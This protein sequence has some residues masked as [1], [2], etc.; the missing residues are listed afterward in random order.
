MLGLSR[1][2]L[3]NYELGRST[4]PAQ[5]IDRIEK[6]FAASVDAP[7]ELEDYEVEFNELF[8]NG[9]ELTDDEWSLIRIV[10]LA[11][12]QDVQAIVADLVRRVE[13]NNA[14]LRFTGNREGTAI[15][16]A[17]LM[18]IAMGKRVFV[19]GT[20]GEQLIG[21]AKLLSHIVKP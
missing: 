15:D 17:R 10:R 3:A 20:S 9:K 21:V 6:Q 4:P 1:S 12:T 18:T 13:Q 19:T 5:L 16:L 7:P 14:G 8:G 11:D 2:G